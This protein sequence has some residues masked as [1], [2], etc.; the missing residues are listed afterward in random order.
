MMKTN[1]K[2]RISRTQRR[3]DTYQWLAGKFDRPYLK[4]G[5]YRY[6][7]LQRWYWVS[8]DMKADRLKDMTPDHLNNTIMALMTRHP[9]ADIKPLIKE[10][11]RRGYRVVRRADLK[12]TVMIKG[13]K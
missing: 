2:K 1:W 7:I 10:A 11:N 13:R 9:E 5:L 6:G 3:R 12:S 8:K 4:A